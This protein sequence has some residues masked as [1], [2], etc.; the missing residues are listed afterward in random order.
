MKE[1]LRMERKDGGQ[2]QDRMEGSM[3]KRSS[4]DLQTHKKYSTPVSPRAHIMSMYM[5]MQ[6]HFQKESFLLWFGLQSTLSQHI[7]PPS[8]LLFFTVNTLKTLALLLQ[9][10]QENG[11]FQK[12]VNLWINALTV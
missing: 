3:D 2:K 7:P 12:S 8:L 11:A 5:I 10:G 6:I 1:A 9:C 4:V